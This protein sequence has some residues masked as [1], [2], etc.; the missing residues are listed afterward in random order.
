[1][2]SHNPFATLLEALLIGSLVLSGCANRE[3]IETPNLY[4]SGG[5]DPFGNC[6]PEFQ[7]NEVD[8]LYATDRLPTERKGGGLEYGFHRSRSLAFGQCVVEIGKDV[9]WPQL[10]ENSL[11]EKRELSLP[12]SIQRISELGR[13]P[14]TPIPFMSQG[15][16]L[17]DD[18]A[19]MA[20]KERVSQ[21]FRAEVARRLSLTQEK[22]AF[23]FIH[24]YNNAFDH[25]IF[26]MTDLWHFMGR[27]G[28]PVVYS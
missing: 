21:S 11:S 19:I 18:P 23:L 13:F 14:E 12:L 26:V 8:I 20:E 5:L 22:E 7:N 2:G 25:S 15:N 28:I 9:P 6:P 24:G 3:L 4:L 1:M 17:V 10:V 27:K 16:Q